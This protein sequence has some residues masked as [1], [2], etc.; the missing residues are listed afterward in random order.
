MHVSGRKDAFTLIEMSIVLIV[1]G[2]LVGGVLVGRDLIKAAEARSIIKQM[3]RIQLAAS[4]FRLKYNCKAGDCPNA[5]QFGLGANGNGD[6]FL[7]CVANSSHLTLG[8]LTTGNPIGCLAHQASSA[9]QGGAYSISRGFGEP[10]RFW[11]HLSAAG[12]IRESV[13]QLPIGNQD[14]TA[15]YKRFFPEIAT[16]GSH[17]VAVM[18]NGRLYIRTGMTGAEAP[19]TR[20]IFG[21]SGG[22]PASTVQRISAKLNVAINVNATNDY[23]EAL[24]QGQRFYVLGLHAAQATP[25]LFHVAAYSVPHSSSG[26]AACAVAN[27]EGGFKFNTSGRARCN[28]MW[29]IDY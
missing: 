12:L 20:P 4:A 15:T 11:V 9:S 17:L 7:G 6:G 8:G 1:I 29:E 18:W 19:Y 21:W 23:P 26:L 25:F 22:L 13:A 14:I 3:E 27:G 5:A 28:F 2:L 24:A 10:Q 16:G